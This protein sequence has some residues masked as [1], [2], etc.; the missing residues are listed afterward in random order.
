LTTNY[1]PIAEQYKRAK[2]QPWRTYIECFTL[3]NLIGEPRGMDVLDVACGEGFYTRLVRER[4]AAS[5]TGVDLSQGMIELARS[6]E[7]DHQLGIEY[8]VADARDLP[9]PQQFDLA[10]AAY[11]LNYARN[12][13]E[14][15][16]MCEGISRS[17]KPGGRFVT[18]NCNPGLNFTTAPS[19]RKYGFETA[20]AGGWREGSPIKWTF[21]LSDGPF[22]VENYHLNIAVHE[23]AFRKAGFREVRW[24]PPQLSP[25]GLLEN[26]PEFWSRLLE[27]PPIT[28]IECFK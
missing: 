21:H 16:A 20:V 17:L 14:L 22:D 5:V 27:H 28:F 12:R 9:V 25:A 19:Y 23:D 1:D 10:V 24:Y 4:G 7:A 11:L 13:D 15:E 3:V 26:G 18:V 8:I 2:Q 6:Q